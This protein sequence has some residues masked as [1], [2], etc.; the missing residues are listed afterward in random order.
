[1]CYFKNMQ[2]NSRTDEVK[3]NDIQMVMVKSVYVQSCE[4]GIYP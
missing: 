2:L 3:A 4:L 1:M